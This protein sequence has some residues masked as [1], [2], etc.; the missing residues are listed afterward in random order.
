MIIPVFIY[1]RL[2]G[3]RPIMYTPLWWWLRLMCHE[4]FRFDD[5]Q[6]WQSFWTSLNGGH[7]DMNHQWVFEQYWGKGSYPPQS[8]LLPPKDYDKLTEMINEPPKPSQGLI[9]LMNRPSPWEDSP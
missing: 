6:I 9:D 2:I 3:F 4:G 7:I 1:K 8:I 5:Y